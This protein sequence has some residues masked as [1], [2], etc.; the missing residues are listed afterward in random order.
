MHPTRRHFRPPFATQSPAAGSGRRQTPFLPTRSNACDDD[1]AAQ[2]AA[3][4]VDVEEPAA[5]A[6]PLAIQLPLTKT[7]RLEVLPIKPPQALSTAT[8]PTARAECVAEEAT[9]QKE[10]LA[11]LT[12][13]TG[14]LPEKDRAVVCETLEWLATAQR[15]VKYL[16]SLRGVSV[17]VALAELRIHPATLLY[18]T[19]DES[20]CDS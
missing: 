19:V 17:E 14:E 11:L 18:S 8:Q 1:E 10:M 13:R 15:C 3:V 6:A 4:S 9:S 7:R 2:E 5:A 20:F 12:S 16:A